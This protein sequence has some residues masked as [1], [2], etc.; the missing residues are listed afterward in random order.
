MKTLTLLVGIS[1]A[2]LSQAATATIDCDAKID[3][4]MNQA[5]SVSNMSV[6]RYKISETNYMK[7]RALAIANLTNGTI[8][9][10][11]ELCGFPDERVAFTVFHEMGHL[12]HS[13]DNMDAY[14]T[15]RIPHLQKEAIA[16]HQAGIIAKKLGMFD[17]LQAHFKAQCAANPVMTDSFDTTNHYNSCSRANRMEPI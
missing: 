2:V 1:V 8:T 7:T 5:A 10:S 16:D 14:N 3:A 13:K 15:G 4:W 17:S 12:I 9:F 11:R 6:P